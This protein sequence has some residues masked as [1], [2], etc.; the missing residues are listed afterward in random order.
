MRSDG[1]DLTAITTDPNYRAI[2]W[3]SSDVVV[4]QGEHVNASGSFESDVYAVDR[5]GS[6]LQALTSDGG[7]KS[8]G[9]TSCDSANGSVY[10]SRTET[11][12]AAV[13]RV[14][15]GS[16]PVRLAPAG[17]GTDSAPSPSPDGSRLAFERSGASGSGVYVSQD[18]GTDATLV[19]TSP[20][21]GP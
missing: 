12:G 9:T 16:G 14:Q 1:S 21:A 5:D 4:L 11:S 10:Y 19:S 3:L 15:V 6:G 2:C 18:D 8:L 20:L 7:S 17:G 13:Y